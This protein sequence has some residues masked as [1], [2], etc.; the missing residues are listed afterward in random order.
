M[1]KRTYLHGQKPLQIILLNNTNEKEESEI[2]LKKYQTCF[3]T[4]DLTLEL[5]EI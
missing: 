5:I 2:Y 4:M 3:W 1:G